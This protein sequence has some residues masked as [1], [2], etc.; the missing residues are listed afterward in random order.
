MNI[1]LQDTASGK[2][3]SKEKDNTFTDEPSQARRFV[4]SIEALQYCIREKRDG[5]Q[6]VMRFD[7]SRD[8]ILF[9]VAATHRALPQ[10]RLS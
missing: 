6:I 10:P 3:V 9:P 1:F 8:D 4:T 7:N 5:L 2:F